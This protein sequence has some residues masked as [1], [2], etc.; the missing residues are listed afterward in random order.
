[1]GR[2]VRTPNVLLGRLALVAV[3]AAALLVV[4]ALPA[5]A[6]A[7]FVSSQPGPGTGLPQA[8]G[9]VVLRFSEPLVLEGSSVDVVDAAGASATDGPVERVEGSPKALRRELGLLPPGVYTVRWTT[10]SPLDGHTLRGEYKFAIGSTTLGDERVEASPLSSEGPL[11][12]AG[13]FVG[14]AGLVVW[15]GAA[16][17]V[18]PSRRAGLSLRRHQLLL[19]WGSGAAAVGTAASLLGTSLVATGGAGAVFDIVAGGRSG[20]LRAGLVVIAL[21]GSLVARGPRWLV[22]G[23]AGLGVLAEA[24]SGHAGSS[25]DP[26]LTTAAFA[27]HLVAVGVW[28]HAVL[29]SLLSERGTGQALR[30]FT[31]VAVGAGVLVALTGVA[32]ASLELTGMRDLVDTAYGR[33]VLLKSVPLL[34]MAAAGITHN[35]RR[36]RQDRATGDRARLRR[37]LV[38]EVVAA[39]VGI[40]VA[41]ALVGFPNPP[42]EDA[43]AVA[44]VDVPGRLQQVLDS[45]PAL[46]FAGATG[47]YVLG[48]TVTPPRPGEVTVLAQVLGAIAGDAIRDVQLVATGPDGAVVEAGLPPCGE[49]CW[50]AEVTLQGRGQWELAVTATSNRGPLEVVSTVELPAPDGGPVFERLMVAMADVESARVNEALSNSVVETVIRSEYRFMAPDRMR[51]DVAGKSSRIAI[52][53]IGYIRSE[54]DVPWTKYPWPGEGF[55]W[56]GAFYRE[57]FTDVESVRVVDQE[58]IGDRP[59]T[60][61]TFVQPSYPAWYRVWVDRETGRILRLEMRASRHVMDQDYGPYDVPLEVE[62]PPASRTVER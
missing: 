58:V 56:P 27:A 51:W 1:M 57:F 4:L 2:R 62:A 36:R 59:A 61:V 22:L 38:A 43:T 45:G 6:H 24:S 20:M 12:L 55:R 37:P 54:P 18:G 17:L 7:S 30:V 47:P 52:G 34:G 31:P 49:D 29:A 25:P 23:L 5:S 14:L 21:V 19:R 11:G 33:T 48:V 15:I 35:R 10:L 60:V 32:S 26:L 8:P 44:S 42:R 41:T 9:E 46:T 3:L 53:D 39:A 40:A 16:L 13:R 28:T 50:E